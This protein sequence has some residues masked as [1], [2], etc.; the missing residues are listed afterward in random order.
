MDVEAEVRVPV[1]Y[2]GPIPVKGR[3]RCKVGQRKRPNCGRPDKALA[4]PMGSSGVCAALH[5]VLPRW[6]FITP[7]CSVTACKLPHE[8]HDFRQSDSMATADPGA[9]AGGGPLQLGGRPFLE[10]RSGWPISVST[11]DKRRQVLVHRVGVVLR[12]DSGQFL[13]S[14]KREGRAYG[15]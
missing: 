3:G 1:S 2:G 6:A 7:L 11:T 4:H 12:W 9:G 14:N 13:H 8:R 10:G 5:S 15:Y